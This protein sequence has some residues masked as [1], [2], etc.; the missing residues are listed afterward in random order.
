[1]ELILYPIVA[2]ALVV[3]GVLLGQRSKTARLHAARVQAEIDEITARTAA[4]RKNNGLS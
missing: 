2:I 1:M 4:V 3:F